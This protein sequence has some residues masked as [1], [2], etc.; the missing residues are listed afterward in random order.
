M[1]VIK[2][3]SL[4]GLF[5]LVPCMMLPQMPMSTKP[6]QEMGA[7][8]GMPMPSMEELE[9]MERA[10]E[11]ERAKMSPEERAQF[12]KDVAQLTKELEQMKPEELE[13]FIE[14]VLFGQPQPGEQAPIEEPTK[15]MMEQPVTEPQP[16]EPVK[17][18]VQKPR[19]KIDEALARVNDIIALTNSFLTK[20]G[21]II[22]FP[23]KVQKWAEQ[24]K[25]RGWKPG[26]TWELL[27]KRLD[28]LVQKLF[29]IKAQDKSN[30]YKYLNDV[31]ED[32]AL[33][34]NLGKLHT[35]LKELEPQV[36]VDDFGGEPV[37][38][39]V[40][41]VI[42]KLMGSYIEALDVLDVPVDL[43]KIIAKFEPTAKK[44]REEESTAGK[45]ALE[46][47][48]KPRKA[49]AT[50]VAGRAETEDLYGGYTPS[51][52]GSYD[53]SSPYGGGYSS[54]GYAPDYGSSAGA[55]YGAGGGA[56]S[57]AAGGSGAGRGASSG[58][59][60]KTDKEAKEGA[61]GGEQA[62]STGQEPVRGGSVRR[63]DKKDRRT[64]KLIDQFDKNI[65]DANKS[66]KVIV[67]KKIE[68]HLTNNAQPVDS[69]I[70]NNI[71]NATRK[72]KA[73]IEDIQPLALRIKKLPTTEKDE[74]KK[75][76]KVIYDEFKPNF[77]KLNSTVKYIQEKVNQAAIPADKKQ[78]YLGGEPVVAPA[79]PKER[80]EKKA[81]EEE[82]EEAPKKPGIQTSSLFE[83]QTA[84]E[85]LKKELEKL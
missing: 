65:A 39:E 68:E 41:D 14:Q 35:T 79:A 52:Y 19:K 40:R 32:E 81:A 4:I 44:L 57:G 48:K 45:K 66:V 70:S 9:A 43:D 1:M 82:L 76:V 80:E 64:S 23:G 55:G 31:I 84:I 53:Y 50:V 49:Q 5:I 33:Y 75:E 71:N 36:D 18:I 46:E 20:V 30:N 22:E 10:V 62:A 63:E 69:D 83:L 67:S 56:G 21:I 13:T 34:S 11:A 37:S 7:P 24:G 27:K 38:P 73:A 15:P 47:S 77:E 16:I 74:Y 61:A 59:R 6:G 8:G 12:D 85:A 51:S 29:T 2:K 60:D 28:A 78:A 72:I 25:I 26:Y 3:M 58:G 17:P 42:R 54:G